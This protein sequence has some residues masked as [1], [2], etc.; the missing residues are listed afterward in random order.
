MP[1][2]LRV[3]IEIPISANAE[4]YNAKI[5]PAP[6]PCSINFPTAIVFKSTIGFVIFDVIA[7]PDSLPIS[8]FLN[9]FAIV[10]LIKLLPNK[11]VFNLDIPC[12]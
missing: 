4:P 1:P 5:P 7:P 12:A 8:A 6:P 2:T 3:I 10:F 9:V 11:N